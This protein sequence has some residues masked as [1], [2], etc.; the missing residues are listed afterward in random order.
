MTKNDRLLSAKV[1][2]IA[3][4]IGAGKNEAPPEKAPMML[5]I[6]LEQIGEDGLSLSLSLTGTHFCIK[7]PNAS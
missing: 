1:R 4:Q 7:V 3:E 6:P 2:A 5:R